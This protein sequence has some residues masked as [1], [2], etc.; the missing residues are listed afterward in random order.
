MSRTRRRIPV[1]V[2]KGF[3]ILPDGKRTMMVEIYRDNRA[4]GLRT[5]DHRRQRARTRQRLNVGDEPFTG[6]I[7]RYTDKYGNY[8]W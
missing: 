2:G 1:D 5:E 6:K 3:H 7:R 4:T 8:I